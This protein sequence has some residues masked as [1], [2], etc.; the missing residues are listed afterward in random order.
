MFSC[1]N[2]T[3]KDNEDNHLLEKVVDFV[4]MELAE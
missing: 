2:R 4:N 3:G 1:K